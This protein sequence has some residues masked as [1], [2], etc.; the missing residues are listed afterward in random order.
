MNFT[1]SLESIGGEGSLPGLNRNH[2]IIAIAIAPISFI[3]GSRSDVRDGIWA[4]Y[5]PEFRLFKENNPL[6]AAYITPHLEGGGKHR[7][8]ANLDT[9]RLSL[10]IPQATCAHLTGVVCFF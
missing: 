3:N 9:I 8:N 6:G 4:V 5:I 2:S 10:D 7:N 1:C